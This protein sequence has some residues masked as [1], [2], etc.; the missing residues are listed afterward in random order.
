MRVVSRICV[1]VCVCVC[2][3]GG[4]GGYSEFIC[5]SK[6]DTICRPNDFLRINHRLVQGSRYPVISSIFLVKISI[7]VLKTK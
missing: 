2:V 3:C 5:K 6:R 4:G 1:C 7:D